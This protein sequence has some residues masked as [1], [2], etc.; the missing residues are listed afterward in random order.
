MRHVKDSSRTLSRLFV[1]VDLPEAVIGELAKIR[2]LATPGVKRIEPEQMHLTLHFLGDAD[3]QATATALEEVDVPKFRLTLNGVGQFA[4]GD[5]SAILWAG[6][7][8]TPELKQLHTAVGQALARQR[9]QPESRPYSPHITLAR[10]KPGAMIHLMDRYLADNAKFQIADV[11]I[12]RF[13]LYSSVPL[14]HGR[15]YRCERSFSLQQPTLDQPAAG[16]NSG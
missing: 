7:I 4:A 10:C 9:F 1:A 13:S 5:R 16:R 8:V 14:R 3:V 11:P 15:D 2:P 6:V 12:T